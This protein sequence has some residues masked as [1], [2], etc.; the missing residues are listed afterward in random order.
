MTIFQTSSE[1]GSDSDEHGDKGDDNDDDNDDSDGSA[2]PRT[3]DDWESIEDSVDSSA[4]SNSDS[5]HT[6]SFEARTCRAAADLV[7]TPKSSPSNLQVH[8]SRQDLSS[9]F[10]LHEHFWTSNFHSSSVST[11]R[12]FVND[13]ESQCCDQ[14]DKFRRILEESCSSSAAET[15]SYH[16]TSSML[17]ALHLEKTAREILIEALKRVDIVLET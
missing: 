7:F 1:D 8:Y 14:R 13:R 16:Y 5:I 17:D 9:L 10:E 11:R 12:D 3:S 2:E 4:S 6:S 15:M